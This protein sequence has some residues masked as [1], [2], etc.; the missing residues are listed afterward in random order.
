MMAA[1]LAMTAVIPGC[2]GS[3]KPA[4][5]PS[6]ISSSSSVDSR[7]S[8]SSQGAGG[9]AASPVPAAGSS[10]SGVSGGGGG[11]SAPAAVPS[12]V[13]PNLDPDPNAARAAVEQ[14]LDVARRALGGA[15]PDPEVALREARLALAVDA[16]S[17]DAA[18]L[19]AHAY[20]LKRLGDTAEVLLDELFKR[21]SAKNNAGLFYVY[22]LVYDQLG[23]KAEAFLAYKNAVALSSGHLSAL[24]NLGIH[25]LSNKQY[26]DA[27]TTFE[28]VT[29]GGRD[30]AEVWNAL[31]SA[32]R[33]HSADFGAAAGERNTLLRQAE[34]AFK[35]ATTLKQNYAA[36]YYNLGLL[37]LDAEPFPS[38]GG[39]LDELARLQRA[40]GYFDEYRNMPGVEMKLYDERMKDVSKLIKREEKKRKKANRP[41]PEG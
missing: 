11:S 24:T 26:R 23:K 20:Y 13:A 8:S 29:Q 21:P 30:T 7:P 38:D 40:K 1:A 17:V 12:I 4:T 9:S 41:A 2:G 6:T 37:Y 27:I 36:A 39:A 19:I 5:T 15:N 34:Q 3:N 25:Q 32:Y 35:K 28:R 31:G 16:S 33:G 14:H 22:G 18:V 10:G